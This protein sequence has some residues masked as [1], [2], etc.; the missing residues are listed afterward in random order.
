MMVLQMSIFDRKP[1]AFCKLTSC[2]AWRCS[3]AGSEGLDVTEQVEFRQIHTSTHV[4]LFRRQSSAPF[5]AGMEVQ[6]VAAH[7]KGVAARGNCR[8]DIEM[9]LLLHRAWP[10]SDPSRQQVAT[11]GRWQL[12]RLLK[13]A[14][15][16]TAAGVYHDI[17]Q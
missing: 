4:G 9:H 7:R 17:K 6:A 15:G 11:W 14:S 13:Q 2:L 10:H 5:R 16:R 1:P 8:G 12:T 3:Y